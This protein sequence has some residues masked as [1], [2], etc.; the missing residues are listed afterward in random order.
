MSLLELFPLN[1]NLNVILNLQSFGH[2]ILHTMLDTGLQILD[3][4]FQIPD[5]GY[6]PLF[7]VDLKIL[8]FSYSFS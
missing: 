6:I 7:A 5:T 3:T 1:L 4:R 8:S 2:W